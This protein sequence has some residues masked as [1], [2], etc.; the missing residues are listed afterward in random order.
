MASSAENTDAAT[1][2]S[3]AV[4][5]IRAWRTWHEHEQLLPTG[6]AASG[7]WAGRSD[8]DA[9]GPRVRHDL[10]AAA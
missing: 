10:H 2:P 9:D 1:R 7:P 4:A 8:L 5:L 6:P 3:L